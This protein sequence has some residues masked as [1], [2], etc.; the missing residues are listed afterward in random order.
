MSELFRKE[1][2]EAKRQKMFGKATK[3]LPISLTFW[4]CFFFLTGLGLMLFVCL[5]V[6]SKKQEVIGFLK[7]NKGILLLYPHTTG[8]VK[9]IMVNQGE[10]VKKGQPLL[11][12]ESNNNGIDGIDLTQASEKEINDQL[13]LQQNIVKNLESELD[14]MQTLLNNNYISFSDYQKKYTQLLDAKNELDQLKRQQIDTSR[15][16]GYTITAPSSGVIA[17]LN[18]LSGDSVNLQKPLLSILPENSQLTAELFVTS[19][20]AG[21]V[22]VGQ[23]VLLK[24]QAYP[25]QQFGVYDA[26]ITQVGKTIMTSDQISAPIKLNQPFYLVTAK[27]CSQYVSVYN[28][29]HLLQSGML[30]DAQIIGEKRT[31]LRWILDPIYSLRGSLTT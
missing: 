23:K 12:I 29:P 16:K 10:G 17:S 24:Y 2:L 28:E 31:I 22:H 7:P 11:T 18:A 9:S 1:A 26:V 6:Y 20:A 19:Q 30:L 5:G 21:F 14:R 3:I 15:S 13:E 27:L 4:L 8:T 25:Y